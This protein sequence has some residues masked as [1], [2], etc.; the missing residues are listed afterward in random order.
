[1]VEMRDLGLN[2]D[3]VGALMAL[4]YFFFI[5]Q[6]DTNVAFP[7]HLS[8]AARGR[9]TESARAARWV[10][11]ASPGTIGTTSPSLLLVSARIASTNVCGY[12][13]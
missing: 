4:A 2:G 10:R 7:Y 11:P 13:N 5:D 12:S 3:L 1:M 6:L 8:S 9:A